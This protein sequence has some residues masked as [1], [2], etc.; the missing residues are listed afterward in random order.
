MSFLAKGDGG[1]VS[2]LVTVILKVY[3]YGHVKI[4]AE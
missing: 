3:Q 2:I 4:I 1:F